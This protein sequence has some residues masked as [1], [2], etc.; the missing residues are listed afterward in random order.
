MGEISTRVK[1]NDGRMNLPILTISAKHGWMTQSKRFS[2]NIAGKEQKKYTLLKKEQL[3]Y[4]HGNSKAAIYGTVFKLSDYDEALVPKVYHSFQVGNLNDATFVEQY[5]HTKKIDRQLRRFISSTARMDGLLNIT[6][7][8]FMHVQF[9]IPKIKEQKNIALLL[10]KINHLISLQQRKLDL[11]KRLKKGFL[12]KMFAGSKSKKPLI[13][14]QGFSDNWE[15]SNLGTLAQIIGGGTPN[16]K[17]PKY[18]NGSINWYVPAEL[19]KGEIYTS[20]SRRTITEL[21]LQNCSAKVLPVGTV[22][23]TSRAGIGKTAILLREATTNQGFQSII[24]KKGKLDSY[25]AFLLT[26]QLKRYGETHGAGSTF[27]EISGKE[28][29]KAP[30]KL[31]SIKEQER[32]SQFNQRID[33]IVSYQ[34]IRING[35]NVIKKFFLQQMFI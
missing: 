33:H 13:R 32:I 16:T 8:D 10:I 23:F 26:N 21:G 4:N 30:I 27:I 12:Q 34:Q 20:H 11:L 6:F 1:G 14:I 29:S 2:T 18:W 17:N 3:S 31:P 19:Y 7:S 25:F 15:L 28:L 22:L 9:F 24:P 35:F 5:F